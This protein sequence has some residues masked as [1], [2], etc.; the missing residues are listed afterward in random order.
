MVYLVVFVAEHL[1]KHPD[2][3]MAGVFIKNLWCRASGV[4]VLGSKA[5][6]T[7]TSVLGF[8]KN[9]LFLNYLKMC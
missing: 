7:T 2:I 9:P 3:P 1:T 6:P 8:H 4:M 5:L